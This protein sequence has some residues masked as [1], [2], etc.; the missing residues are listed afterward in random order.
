[1]KSNDKVLLKKFLKYFKPY[2]M[3]CFFLLLS[4]LTSVMISIVQPI[5]WSKLITSVFG[6][7]INKL[8]NI[9]ALFVI[10]FLVT[11]I[12]GFIQSTLTAY[13][14]THIVFDMQQ[15]LFKNVLSMK[16]KYFDEVSNG[17]IISKI[18]GDTKQI[19][20][21]IIKEVL[22]DIIAVLKL[23]FSFI[24]M[25][26]ISWMLTLITIITLPMVIFYYSKNSKK[27]REKQT[28]LREKNDNV[29]SVIQQSVSGIFN[30]KVLGL[31]AIESQIF[32]HSNTE[33]RKVEFNFAIFLSVFQ[34]VITLLGLV[35]EVAVFAV[36][37]Y[38][39]FVSII[40]AEKFIQYTSYSQ[41]FSNSSLTLVN[42]VADYQKVIVS[43]R[44]LYEIEEE[45]SEQHEQFGKIALNSKDISV[46]LCNVNF[47]YSDIEIIKNLN[48]SFEKNAITLLTGESGC[49]KST[50]IKLILGLYNISDGKILINNC[51]ITQLSEES[52]RNTVS[53]VTQEHFLLNASIVDNFRFL[54]PNIQIEKIKNLCVKCGIDNEISELPN[55]YNT[56][57]GENGKN[58]SVGQLQRLSIA[59]VLAKDTPIILFDEPTAALDNENSKK[60]FEVMNKIKENKI[61]V[62]V[63]HSIDAIS[64][65]DRVIDIGS[66]DMATS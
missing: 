38:F 54:K 1:M 53:V 52:L 49:G 16:M 47:S 58:F 30:I 22:P 51:D 5:L 50:L 28:E 15:K 57:I 39:V 64:Y 23:V 21:L 6:E 60:I 13:L 29:F 26:R 37:G 63:S 17:A 27:M 32:D 65:A 20:D 36:G 66:L 59:R 56:I 45:L 35:S 18:T 42:L 62:V 8:Y 41:Q 4:I 3:Q 40:T 33:K 31:K 2:R 25:V 34:M 9:V 55:G 43:I 10:L 46:E 19:V 24:L 61:L 14:N 44:R 12:I 48:L 7:N 11:I